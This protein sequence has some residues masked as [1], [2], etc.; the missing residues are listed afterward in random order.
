MINR[1]LLIHKVCNNSKML[2]SSSWAI[3]I[4]ALV[5]SYSPRANFSS[6]ESLCFS[7]L[8]IFSIHSY[9]VYKSKN[10]KTII[11][12]KDWEVSIMFYHLF[13]YNKTQPCSF[14]IQLETTMEWLRK[15]EQK[16]I[17]GAKFLEKYCKG[18]FYWWDLNMSWLEHFPRFNKEFN[19]SIRKL[20]VRAET[21]P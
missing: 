13:W 14:L 15:F 10:R 5:F 6:F 7:F 2:L 4:G 3:F 18:F 11:L 17:C 20:R 19:N 8:L 1:R 12:S 9:L 16:I 21:S